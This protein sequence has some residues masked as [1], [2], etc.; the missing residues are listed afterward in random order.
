ML[1]IKLDAK[2]P[3]VKLENRKDN[4][5]RSLSIQEILPLDNNDDS[6]LGI[7]EEVTTTRVRHS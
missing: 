3:P 7:E 2:P 1:Y 6:G 5:D 4:D